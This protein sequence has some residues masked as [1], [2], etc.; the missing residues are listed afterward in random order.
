MIDAVLLFGLINIVFE[1]VLLSMMPVRFRL[2]LLGSHHSQLLLHCTFLLVN[3]MVHWGTLIGTMASVLAFCSSILTV[4]IAQFLF[5]KI[6]GGRY[7]TVGV[8]KYSRSEIT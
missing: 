1:M 5:G 7:Y 2:K 4:R 6:V 8:I 3:L